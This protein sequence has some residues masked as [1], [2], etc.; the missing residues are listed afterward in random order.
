MIYILLAGIGYVYLYPVLFMVANS[1]KDLEDLLNPIVRWIPTRVYW[2][3]YTRANHVMSFLPVL[4]ETVYVVA[5]PSAVQTLA[6]ALVG[7]GFARFRFPLKALWF[8]LMLATFIIP[9]Q[10]TMIPEFLVYKRLGLLGSV[11]SFVIPAALGQGLRSA[12]FILIFYQFTRMLPRSMEEA[13]LVDGAGGLMVFLR[14]VV[15]ISGPAFL[16]SFLFS[17]V[18]YWNETYLANLYFGDV[19]TTLPLQLLR[20]VASY[21][22]IY[23]V[24]AQPR[25]RINEAIKMAGTV[26]TIAPVVLIYF[27]LQKWFVEGVDRT[28]VTGE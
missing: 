7:Y 16:V 19:L 11:L 9:P 14:V 26:L 4:L 25:D 1:L 20:F 24:G 10:V 8:P 5:L 28:G 6:A 18:W 12:L 22:R 15:P 13:A 3:N 17:F 27:V 2:G 23:P 21:E